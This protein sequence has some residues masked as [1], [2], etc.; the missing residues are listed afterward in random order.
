MV[1]AIVPMIECFNLC[2]VGRCKLSIVGYNAYKLSQFN[3]Q[4]TTAHQHACTIFLW[5]VIIILPI[6]KRKRRTPTLCYINI[7]NRLYNTMVSIYRNYGMSVRLFIGV[8]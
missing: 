1:I 2:N 6:T 8:L 3:F 4:L 7:C 5:I